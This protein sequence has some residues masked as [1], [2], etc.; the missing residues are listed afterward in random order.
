MIRIGIDAKLEARLFSVAGHGKQVSMRKSDIQMSVR[1]LTGSHLGKESYKLKASHVLLVLLLV[2]T[3]V[4]A[5]GSAAGGDQ[6]LENVKKAQKI[7]VGMNGS[8]PYAYFDGETGDVKGF[9][10]DVVRAVAKD[11]GIPEVEAKLLNWE[12]LIPGLQAGRFD[13]IASGMWITDA[14]KEQVNFSSPVSRFGSVIITAKGNPLNITKWEDINGKVVGMDLGQGDYDPAIAMGA[15]VKTYTKQLPE[16]V[17]ELQAGRVD[18]I[19][20]DGLY[21]RIKMMENPEYKD[22]IEI[23]AETPQTM[24]SGH[25]FKKESQALLDAYNKSLQKLIDDG[26]VFKILQE[27]GLTEMNLPK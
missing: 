24:N 13:V 27:Y 2:A 18:C 8:P 11:M 10:V 22:I 23:V 12:A 7:I 1:R 26:T 15:E 9:E 21:A 3:V 5:C 19:V 6:S 16:I 4:A 17:A 25:A 14:R 20:Y